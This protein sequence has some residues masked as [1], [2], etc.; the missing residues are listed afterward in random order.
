[1]LRCSVSLMVAASLLS[2]CAQGQFSTQ[3]A[4]I[5]HDDGTDS[6]RA[7]LVALDSTGNYFGADILKGA[8]IGAAGGALAGGV[9]GR[10]WQSALIGAASGAALGASVGYW[11]SLQQ[12]A[13]DQAGMLSQVRGD[14][15]R[16]GAQIDRT[17]IAFDQLMDCR[18]NQA[19]RIRDAYRAGRMDR[20]TAVAQMGVI[21][22]RAE[23]DLQVAK[24]ING[25]ISARAEQFDVAANNLS[26][27]TTAEIAARTP[28]T[29]SVVVRQAAALKLTPDPAAPDI[30]QLQPKQ[31]VTIS[32][33]RG[34]YALVQTASGGRGYT[35]V[36]A[37]QGS[38][39]KAQTPSTRAGSET[40]GQEIRNLAGS[41][42]ARR[43]DFAQS[44][45]VSE[46][47]MASGFEVAG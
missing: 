25:Q 9:I 19:Q 12:Q 18:F 22:Q 2:G 5:G 13:R 15:T 32:G 14:M 4:R 30:A 6:C 41:N 27:G 17:Q 28:A 7:H 20:A 35:P 39:G 1:M 10:D 40:G 31:A 47:A 44:V 43:D 23:Q 33:R 8:A 11:S 38:G 36:D 37:L 16:E 24:Q 3:S 21:R 45:S 34:N 26:P 42:A 46:K 29:R